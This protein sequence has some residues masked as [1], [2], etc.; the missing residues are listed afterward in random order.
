VI[1]CADWTPD[2]VAR[3]VRRACENNGKH[4]FIPCLAAGGPGSTYPG[5]YDAVSEEIGR[6]SKEF[7]Q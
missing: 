3:E 7:F 4:Y 1:D 6:I 5:V 2:L